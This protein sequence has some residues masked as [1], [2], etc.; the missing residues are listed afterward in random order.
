M[1][2]EVKEFF[3]SKITEINLVYNIKGEISSKQFKKICISKNLGKVVEFNEVI[4]IR[5]WV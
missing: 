5:S 4:V 2:F 3:E 1:D